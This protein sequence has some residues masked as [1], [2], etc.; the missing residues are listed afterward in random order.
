MKWKQSNLLVEVVIADM[1]RFLKKNL[2]GLS[3]ESL[4]LLSYALAYALAKFK[5]TINLFKKLTINV[6]INPTI[7]GTDTILKENSKKNEL[8]VTRIEILCK[9]ESLLEQIND[10]DLKYID[11]IA[12][13]CI[14]NIMEY[15]NILY[16]IRPIY[17]PIKMHYRDS[18]EKDNN[19]NMEW[20]QSNLLLVEVVIADMEFQ[21]FLEE[22][23]VV[24]S[25]ES[26]S[27]IIASF[28]CIRKVQVNDKIIS[29][30]IEN[31]NDQYAKFLKF[32]GDSKSLSNALVN[33]SD[34]ILSMVEV[35]KEENF[36]EEELISNLKN[37]LSVA[38]KNKRESIN[39]EKQI[40]K[41]EGDL[42]N[43]KSELSEHCNN[44]SNNPKNIESNTK[45]ELLAIENKNGNLTIFKNFAVIVR[46]FISVITMVAPIITASIIAEN[47]ETAETFETVGKISKEIASIAETLL[48][49]MERGLNER[50][51][52]NG[53]KII[54]LN[55]QLEDE[56][57]EF[58]GVIKN[59]EKKLEEITMN[60]NGIFTHWQ[61]QVNSL[62]ANIDKLERGQS[63]LF[64]SAISKNANIIKK[65]ALEYN[66]IMNLIPQIELF[67]RTL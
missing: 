39:Y 26:L 9:I 56:R 3:T 24:L 42:I 51:E 41:I 5:S 37:L 6:M 34:D 18:M 52:K 22:N 61:F 16:Q 40:K 38:K 15:E 12:S 28:L 35:I 63:S 8:N 54:E 20:K 36:K 49:N 48:L 50:I 10:S 64:D 17:L 30:Q 25:T 60:I 58:V 62:Q 55:A 19:N 1:E 53:R 32:C 47:A 29:R 7:C 67:V 57:E 46:K 44:I 65:K 14:W 27:L 43:I 33:Y 4:L 21:Q 13:I 66:R 45:K 23:P 31:V 11:K 59:L 2:V